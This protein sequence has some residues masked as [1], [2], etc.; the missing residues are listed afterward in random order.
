MKCF[1]TEIFAPHSERIR[2]YRLMAFSGHQ[3]TR[4]SPQIAVAGDGLLLGTQPPGRQEERM[5][6]QA[7]SAQ[8]NW[9]RESRDHVVG[10]PIRIPR[11]L[12][13]FP[14]LPG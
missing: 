8:N 3:P 10:S 5:G 13:T 7:I 6:S 9:V 1:F 4:S 2:L 11:Q 14:L 12:T